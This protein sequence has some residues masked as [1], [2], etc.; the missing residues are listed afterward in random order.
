MKVDLAQ[1]DLTSTPEYKCIFKC[2][3]EKDGMLK[4]GVLSED[5]ISKFLKENKDLGLDAAT[6]NKIIKALPNCLE[7]VKNIDDLC[8]KSFSLFECFYKNAM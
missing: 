2:M 7:N 3:L 4:N 8:V 6:K 1:K 5:L